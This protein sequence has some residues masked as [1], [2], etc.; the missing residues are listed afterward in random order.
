MNRLPLVASLR[1]LPITLLVFALALSMGA[2]LALP[3]SL[4]LSRMLSGPWNWAAQAAFFETLSASRPLITLLIRQLLLLAIA[5]AIASPVLHM[6]WLTALSRPTAPGKAV[7]Q[8]VRLSMRAL[9]VSVFVGLIG[10]LMASPFALCAWGLG[11]LFD[12]ETHAPAHD[13]S[14]L[15]S[16]APV[17]L[18]LLVIATWH[19]LARARALEE[20]FFRS[21]TRS[22]RHAFRPR[23][24]VRS[25][26]LCGSG[27]VLV[28]LA[29][30]WTG[31]F[32]EHGFFSWL[33]A[34]TVLH[35]SVF[36]KLFLRSLWLARALACAEPSGLEETRQY[37]ERSWP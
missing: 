22:A 8:G 35:G 26:V 14:I 9:C 18:V 23:V 13:L 11:K 21:V 32:H 29:Q 20:G 7:W 16:L 1:A 15:I 34:G 17:L 30:W 28:L 33:I 2:P 10:L 5:W 25:L 19:D 12:V 37:D 31:T 36:A 27:S 6:A 3:V 24:L 4:E